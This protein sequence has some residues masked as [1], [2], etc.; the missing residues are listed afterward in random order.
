MLHNAATAPHKLQGLYPDFDIPFDIVRGHHLIRLFGLHTLGDHW[1]I[2][3]KKQR[4]SRNVVGKPCSK[5]SP[6]K[7][8]DIRVYLARG[9]AYRFAH[10]DNMPNPCPD[11][12]E[13]CPAYG[14]NVPA[15]KTRLMR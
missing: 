4:A 11:R 15:L 12:L 14:K 1:L 8:S 7:R 10:A 2:G 5:R 13:P 6:D 3:H 9:S